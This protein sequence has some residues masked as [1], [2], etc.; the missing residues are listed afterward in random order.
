VYPKPEESDVRIVLTLM[1][2]DEADVIAAFLDHHLAQGVDLFV[3]T[4]NGS[5]DGTAEI[6]EDYASRDL[7][8][9]RHDPVHRKQQAALVTGMARDAFTVHGAD[10][11][12]NADAD[13]FFVAVDPALTLRQALEG[14]PAE[15]A[16]FTVPVTNLTGAPAEEGTGIQRLVYR[17]RRPVSRLREVGIRAHPTSDA[18]HVGDPDVE[19]V[20]GNH[21]VS[22]PSTG[23]PPQEFAIEVL[24]LPWRSWGQYRRKIENTGRSYDANPD[25]TPSPAHHGMRDWAR[26]KAGALLPHYLIRHPDQAELASGL[27]AGWFVEERRLADS[28]ASPVADVPL[29]PAIQEALPLLT[30]TLEEAGRESLL[31]HESNE[32]EIGML[33]PRVIELE[34]ELARVVHDR[35][36]RESDRVALRRLADELE[37]ELATL[38]AR[39]EVR[40]G[41]SIRR[42]LHRDT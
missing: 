9:L 37:I 32:R 17:D 29:A 3:V 10:W 35:D 19:V 21:E 18:I 15:L 16:S 26:L 23:T 1:V 5:V 24:H 25:A 41:G 12:V 11:V 34:A 28:L 40:L 27:E 22:I 14:T 36:G 30:A 2:R 4:D 38:R 8:D 39:R 20:Q 6:L 13:E 7:V 42:A 31:E 33:R